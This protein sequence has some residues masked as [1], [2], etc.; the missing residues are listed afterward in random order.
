[1]GSMF[2]F[3]R[4]LIVAV[5]IFVGVPLLVGQVIVGWRVRLKQAGMGRNAVPTGE[6]S[7]QLEALQQSVDAMAL[8]VERISE[9]QRAAVRPQIEAPPETG[10][11]TKRM[12]A[13]N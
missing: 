7:H 1:V 6:L 11:A 4:E 12:G 5:V 3:A 2:G 9:A 13:G 8:E 10:L